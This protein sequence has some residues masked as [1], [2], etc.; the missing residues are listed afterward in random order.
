MFNFTNRAKFAPLSKSMPHKTRR[1]YRKRTRKGGERRNEYILPEYVSTIT[2]SYVVQNIQAQHNLQKIQAPRMV[3]K[4]F[5]HVSQPVRVQKYNGHNVIPQYA[6][7]MPNSPK[8]VQLT[9]APAHNQNTIQFVNPMPVGKR[10]VVSYAEPQDVAQPLK[11]LTP[12]FIQPLTQ[13]AVQK[14]IK[15]ALSRSFGTRKLLRKQRV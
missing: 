5:G 14:T 11:L 7:I 2:P 3:E 13:K 9:Y 10:G 6:T 12:Q 8:P 4:K 15:P 1:V